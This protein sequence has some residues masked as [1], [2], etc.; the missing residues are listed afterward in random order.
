M[1]KKPLITARK[2]TWGDLT[3]EVQAFSRSGAIQFEWITI[4]K[5]DRVGDDPD[6]SLLAVFPIEKAFNPETYRAAKEKVKP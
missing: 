2:E 5:A 3:Q 1:R 4:I 6:A